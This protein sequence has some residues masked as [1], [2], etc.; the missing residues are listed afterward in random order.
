MK[1]V[2]ITKLFKK[3]YSFFILKLNV[4]IPS[5]FIENSFMLLTADLKNVNVYKVDINKQS[6]TY[7][8][9]Q[10]DKQYN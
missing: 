3:N 10:E 4:Q 2:Q 9:R 1:L 5:G 8:W 6:V 7:L